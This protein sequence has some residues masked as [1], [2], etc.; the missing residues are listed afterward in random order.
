MIHIIPIRYKYTMKKNKKNG[1]FIT[2]EGIEG[3]GK[4]TQV[5]LLK[6]YIK[7]KNKSCICVRE[8]GSTIIG[9]KLRMLITDPKVKICTKTELLMIQASRAQLMYEII[10]PSLK[11][12]DVVLSDRFFDSSIAYQ[13]VDGASIKNIT[14]LNNFASFGKMPD[15]TFILD[16]NPQIGLDRANLRN[17]N[18]FSDK[19]EQKPIEFHE[20]VRKIF[21]SLRRIKSDRKIKIISGEKTIIEIH[22]KIIKILNEEFENF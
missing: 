21:L 5:A 12:N 6:D 20:K 18:T 19:F 22:K 11:S 1:L 4:T 14:F 15:I 16:I 9:E 7:S 17:N 8:P 3:A 2:F 13:G 10:L